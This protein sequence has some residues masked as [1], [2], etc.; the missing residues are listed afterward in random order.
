[1][2]T[3]VTEESSIAAAAKMGLSRIPS[4]GKSTPAATHPAFADA[5]DQHPF[6]IDDAS[7]FK[8][9]IQIRLIHS[10]ALRSP[11]IYQSNFI[12]CN[13]VCSGWEGALS[14]SSR[15]RQ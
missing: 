11:G 3:T 15:Y 13:T 2:V 9:R 10:M 7:G 1:L 5:L 8:Q 12:H 14:F 6:F 4:K